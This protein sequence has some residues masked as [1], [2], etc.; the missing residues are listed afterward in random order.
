MEKAYV[1]MKIRRGK[2]ADVKN[3]LSQVNGIA[4]VNMVSGRYDIIVRIECEKLS[5]ITD[6]IMNKIHKTEGVERSET[7]I[8]FA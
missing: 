3:G 6:I 4:E 7:L 8:V 5:A 1:L 2:G